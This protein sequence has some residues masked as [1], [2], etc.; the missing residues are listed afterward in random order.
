MHAQVI[1]HQSLAFKGQLYSFGETF[2]VDGI[3]A[4]QLLRSGKIA[5]ATPVEPAPAPA[6]AADLEPSHDVPKKQGKTIRTAK[7][8]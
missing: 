3:V 6:P 5:D 7:H 1:V 8:K 2:D 4:E